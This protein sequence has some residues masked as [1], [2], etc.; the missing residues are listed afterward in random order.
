M[1]EYGYISKDP[2]GV[3]HEEPEKVE[4]ELSKKFQECNLVWNAE[5]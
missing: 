5:K 2:F 3:C 1:C 4:K